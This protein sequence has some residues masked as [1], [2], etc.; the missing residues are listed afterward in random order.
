ML[1]PTIDINKD[2][3]EA[4]EKNGTS[5]CVDLLLK[6]PHDDMNYHYLARTL[7]I[8][9]LGDWAASFKKVYVCPKCGTTIGTEAK[10][11]VLNG[12]SL[13]LC[14]HCRNELKSQLD[15]QLAG[16]LLNKAA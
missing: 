2:I 16:L 10:P 9:G 1:L 6:V 4:L 11:L 13:Y 15:Q 7:T 12:K 14:D 5:G 8:G 3:A